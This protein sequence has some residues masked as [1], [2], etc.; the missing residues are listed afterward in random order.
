MS[1]P[2]PNVEV[3]VVVISNAKGD[4]FLADFNAEWGCF[5]LPMTKR[6]VLPPSH[7]KEQ[8]QRETPLQAAMRA[9][10]EVLGRPLLPH[11]LPTP[12]LRD[13]PPF[14]RSG[15]DGQWKRYTYLPFEMKTEL[16]PRPLPGH[17]AVWLS[18]EEFQTAEP[19]SPTARAVL[20]AAP[21]I[22]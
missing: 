14:N 20:L 17:T 21:S 13:I 19:I 3:A 6:R 8:E 22:K 16:E 10:V 4:Q 2:F 5:T 12:L 15:R 11:E 18:L 7:E 9:A 1:S